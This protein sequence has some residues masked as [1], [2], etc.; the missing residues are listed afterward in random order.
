MDETGSRLESGSDLIR[1]EFEGAWFADARLSRRLVQVAEALNR[2]PDASFPR[3]MKSSSE[4]EGTY[5]FL[6]NESVTPEEILAPHFTATSSRVA[7]HQRV[8]IVHDTTEFRF[9]G[10][11]RR[12]GLGVL[13]GPGKGQG[14]YAHCSLAVAEGS[15]RDALGLLGLETWT[16]KGGRGK[17]SP[18]KLREDAERESLRW[19]NAAN[20][21]EMAVRGKAKLVHVMDREGDAY[22]TLHALH[23]RSQ[24]FVIRSN[25]DRC[26]MGEG[27]SRLRERLNALEYT[28]FRTVPLSKRKGGKSTEGGKRRASKTHP[29]RDGRDATLQISACEVT[30]KRTVAAGPELN[31]TLTLNVVRVTEPFPPEGEEPVDW[32]LLSTLDISTKENVEEIVDIYRQRWLIEEFFKAL[33][34]GCS[35]EQRQLESFGALVNALAIFGPIAW[36]LLRLR[37]MSRTEPDRPASDAFTP[38]QLEILQRVPKKPIS[39]QATVQEALYAVARL[40]GFL[41]QNGQPG[42]RTLGLGFQELLTLER[43]Y[44]AARS[45]ARHDPS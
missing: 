18:K 8:L 21:V 19:A 39:P 42:W 15:G 24:D 31:E 14:F 4:L 29:P 32:V 20:R 43:G 44:F 17:I 22:E 16:R 45:T 33:K 7:A 28:V 41:D 36:R 11:T 37:S 6:N 25:H 27:A 23:T 5:R 12:S 38:V 1:D 26:I 30:I 10:D 13:A 9:T 40:G 35:F 34:T 3:M 2:E